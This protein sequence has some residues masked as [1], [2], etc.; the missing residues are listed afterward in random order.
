[1]LSFGK[2]SSGKNKGIDPL[3]NSSK[4]DDYKMEETIGQGTYGKVKL[5]THIQT[6]EKVAIKIINKKRLINNGDNERI[7]NEIK[8]MTKLN[9]PNVLKAF[10]VFEDEINYYIVMERPI[11]GDLFN[12]ICSKGRLSM[13][14]SSF[15]YYQIVNAVDYLHKNKI[16]HRDMK[17]ENIMLT[18]DMIVKIGDFGLSKYFKSTEVKLQTNCGS[19]CYSA[20]EVLRGNR[21]KP[22]PVDIWGV[23]IILY[24]MICGELP[25]EDE[26]E[27]ILIRKVT[28]CNYTCPIFVSQIFKSLFRRILCS[29]PNERLTIDQI[30]MNC[31]YNMGRANFYKYFKIYGEDG[32]LLPQVKKFIKI[33]A[34]KSLEVAYAMEISKDSEKMTGYKIFFN[35][36]MHDIPWSLYYIPKSSDEGVKPFP[37]E[38]LVKFKKNRKIRNR[39]F[40][41]NNCD[42]IYKN[43]K[44]NIKKNNNLNK[45]NSKEQ[46]D[47]NNNDDVLLIPEHD[48]INDAIFQEQKN[49]E[50]IKVSKR[51]ID[52]I[53]KLGVFSHS[54]DDNNDYKLNSEKEYANQLTNF[55]KKK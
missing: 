23:G 14:E 20:P 30:K 53:R 32:D 51:N 50:Q 24:C 52:G 5:A 7:L 29:N 21:Y 43:K 17:P 48:S 27:D 40:D 25:F 34:L 13:E 33:K 16:V 42:K 46:N 39:S 31:I 9:H 4:L 12:Y 54:F 11:K 26:K 18:K 10:E 19:P 45:L 22:I 2:T 36:Y 3:K 49:Y 44:I 47:N 1:M 41:K 6:N 38:K 37:E 28:L 15:I 8:I 55:D 35:K